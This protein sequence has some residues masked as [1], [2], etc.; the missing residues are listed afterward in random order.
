MRTN[1][2][3]PEP[4]YEQ[5]GDV[6]ADLNFLIAYAPERAEQILADIAAAVSEAQQTR[7]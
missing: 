7:H 6:A 2:K 1:A 3:H 5:V 4:I